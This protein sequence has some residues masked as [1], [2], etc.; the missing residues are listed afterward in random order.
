MRSLDV[1]AENLKNQQNVVSEEV[2]VNVL[3]QPYASFEWLDLWMN[4][5]TNWFNA[6]NFYGDLTE[7]EAATLEDVTR[8][9]QVLLRAKQRGADG[10]RRCEHRRSEEDDRKTLRRYSHGECTRETRRHRAGTGQGEAAGTN[11][12]LA[13][14]PA[15]AIGYHLPDQ[16]SPDFAPMV[17]LNLILQGDDSSRL[18]QR[19]I[20]EKEMTLESERR[21]EPGTRQRI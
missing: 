19:L 20:K 14:L 18:Y 5:N 10:R 3:N 1:S 13:N 8:V 4:A 21:C 15:L 12:Q 16:K 2:R 11:R 9:L 6:H 7:I 17:L